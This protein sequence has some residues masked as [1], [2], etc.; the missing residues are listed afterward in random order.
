MDDR[1]IFMRRLKANRESLELYILQR[2]EAERSFELVYL[3]TFLEYES[4]LPVIRERLLQCSRI[5]KWEGP[6]Y[7][8]LESYLL[9]DQYVYQRIYIRAIEYIAKQD[10]RAAIALTETEYPI[11]FEKYAKVFPV[12]RKIVDDSSPGFDWNDFDAACSAWWLL[13]KLG[14]TLP[15]Y[16]VGHAQP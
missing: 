8:L 5:Y 14:H 15:L 12:D 1:E 13:D 16:A 2:L 11:L 6:N 3:S 9:D 10:I 4:A 7:Y